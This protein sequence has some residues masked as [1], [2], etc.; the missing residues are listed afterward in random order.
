MAVRFSDP[1][2]QKL[3]DQLFRNLAELEQGLWDRL[4]KLNQ[5]QMEIK[6]QLNR[7]E[8]QLLSRR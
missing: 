4:E 5:S 6:A 8:G 2:M 1:E 3:Y 7:I